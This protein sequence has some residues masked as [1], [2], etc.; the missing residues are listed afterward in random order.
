M[1]KKQTEKLNLAELSVQP[2][3]A[4]DAMKPG[5]T[6]IREAVKSEHPVKIEGV[7]PI[8]RTDYR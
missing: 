2:G 8:I 6:P 5:D 4:V 3:V 1:A 7:A